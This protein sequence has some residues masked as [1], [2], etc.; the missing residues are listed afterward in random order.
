MEYELWWKSAEALLLTVC[1]HV[2]CAA[3]GQVTAVLLPRGYKSLQLLLWLSIKEAASTHVCTVCYDSQ[4]EERGEVRQRRRIMA[5]FRYS[6]LLLKES[7]KDIYKL[8]C[9]YIK[10]KCWSFNRQGHLSKSRLSLACLQN[11]T[12]TLCKHPPIKIIILIARLF[13]GFPSPPQHL[14]K[15]WGKCWLSGSCSGG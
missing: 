15:I 7:C 9:A 14:V 4:Q 5:H 2:I 13:R 1:L 12:L 10:Q 8:H 3:R 6:P 11:I